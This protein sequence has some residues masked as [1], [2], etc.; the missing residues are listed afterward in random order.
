MKTRF[1]V[2]RS[3]PVSGKTFLLALAFLCA[4]GLLGCGGGGGGE[5]G[6]VIPPNTNAPTVD[7]WSPQDGSTFNQ[8]N[9]VNF[10][11][12]ARDTED[13]LLSGNSVS[14]ESS[15]DGQIGTG[16][17]LSLNN[18]WPG[19]HTITVTATDSGGKTATDSV[20]IIIL[21]HHA[22]SVIISS[23][24]DQEEF[25]Q[26]E[27]ISFEGSAFDP[28]DGALPGNSLVWTSSEEG[29]IGTG[30]SFT[31][32]DLSDG[33]HTITLTATDSEGKTG[34]SS[35]TITI[36]LNHA[37]SV[38]ISSPPDQEEFAQGESISFEGSAFDTEDGALPGDSLDWTSSR[39]GWIGTGLSFTRND[40][41]D[42]EHTITLT[43]T[44]S[45]GIEGSEVRTITVEASSGE[46]TFGGSGD[47][48]A[49]AIQQTSDGGYI[50]AG[51]KIIPDHVNWCDVYLVKMKS[52][53][54][55]EWEKTFGGPD[56]EGAYTVQQTSDGGYV[57]GGYSGFEDDDFYVLKLDTNGVEQW[58]EKF[59]GSGDEAITSLQQTSDGY[60]LAGY[61]IDEYLRSNL[62]VIKLDNSHEVDWEVTI[63]E[64]T[65]DM[66][67]TSIQQ[68]MDGDYIVAGIKGCYIDTGT[69][70]Y[71]YNDIYIA[72][73]D[74]DTGAV[75]AG[76]PKIIG[77][78]DN[79]EIA[80]AIRQTKDGGYI[81]AGSILDQTDWS[82]DFYVIKLDSSGQVARSKTFGGNDDDEAYAVQQTADE[83]YIVAGYTDSDGSGGSDFYILK[84]NKDL[85][86]EWDQ[87]IGGSA[88][89]VANSIQQTTDGGYVVAGSVR[90]ESGYSDVYVVKLDSSGHI[91]PF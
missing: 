27:S 5:S 84:L 16:A 18:L 50:V 54:M 4:L 53:G 39:D 60:I 31:R 30:L 28:E 80:E 20:T 78:S 79:D 15:L 87:T 42:G 34:D 9:T 41:S 37:P 52:N 66:E 49:Y 90:S 43:A 1:E 70:E 68:T 69:E 59:G 8:G 58:S 46:K 7:I 51:Y 19:I 71:Y 83:G 57:V 67:A 72:K 24:L 29:Q 56:W 91:E 3:I 86:Y 2:L 48:V 32:N 88:D 62:V 23:P 17:S 61:A 44:D 64:D 26:G 65:Y 33:E 63:G 6:T 75:T 25:A 76:W 22:P 35:V 21:E 14:W 36:V 73:L 10:G 85:G 81:V 12:E 89:E 38:V 40:L 13:G 74:G 77:S 11:V 45:D 47:E 82:Y 55:A